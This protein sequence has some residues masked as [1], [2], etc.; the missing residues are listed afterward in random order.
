M[1][2]RCPCPYCGQLV[3]DEL[4][5]SYGIRPVC[6]GRGRPWPPRRAYR[7]CLERQA[8]PDGTEPVGIRR[9]LTEFG[10]R[11]PVAPPLTE[12]LRATAGA[13][14]PGWPSAHFTEIINDL[15]VLHPER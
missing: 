9:A 1:S 13:E 14:A 3:L 6:F 15:A 10:A 7:A 2:R 4:P 8:P 5:G 12:R 11:T